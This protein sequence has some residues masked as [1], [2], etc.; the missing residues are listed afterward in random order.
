MFTSCPS[1][2]QTCC[3]LHQ[4]R[5]CPHPPSLSHR[6]RAHDLAFAHSLSPL[7][8]SH[9]RHQPHAAHM[10]QYALLHTT[11]S[12]TQAGVQKQRELARELLGFRVHVLGLGFRLRKPWSRT[13]GGAQPCRTR[14]RKNRNEQ[15]CLLDIE[16]AADGVDGF[17]VNALLPQLRQPFL[18]TTGT[19]SFGATVTSLILERSH[20]YTGELHISLGAGGE[21]FLIQESAV[22]V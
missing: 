20:R 7:S 21:V 4:T 9:S 22:V 13:D 15:R 19:Q 8:L 14:R 16:G 2:C 18:R 1:S 6:P 12:G 11:A 3:S 5:P 17:G 10:A